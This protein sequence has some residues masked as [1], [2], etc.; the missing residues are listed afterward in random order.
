MA[1]RVGRSRRKT[2]NI[3]KQH[4]YTKSKV[5]LS[6][7]FQEFQSGDKVAFVANKTL[8][9]QGMYFRRFHGHVGTVL[10]QKGSCYQV[11]LKDG[12]KEKTFNVHPVH[13]KKV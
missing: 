3:F 5:P 4:Y 2:K 6:R 11:A 8:S 12:S 9:S 7:Y 1:M 13:L 10:G